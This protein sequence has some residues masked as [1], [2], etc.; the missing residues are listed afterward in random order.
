MEILWDTHTPAGWADRLAQ[1]G[2]AAMQQDWRY[3]AVAGAMGAKAGRAVLRDGGRDLALAQVLARRGLRVVSRGP[4]WLDCADPDRRRAALRRLARCTSAMVATPDAPLCGFGL[5]PVVTPRHHALWDLTPDP[6]CLRAALAPKWRSTLT[7]AEGDGLILTRSPAAL[8]PLLAAE[9]AQR[10]TRGY[11]ALPSAFARAWA[12]APGQAQ[13]LSWRPGGR[14]EA[15]ILVLRHGLR[16][17]YHI[18]WASDRGRA[19]HAHWPLL[20]HMALNLRAAGVTH[21][22][23]GDVD[24]ERNPGLARFKLGTG[25]ALVSLGATCLVLPG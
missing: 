25:A 6:A 12:D 8:E 1:A 21:L 15:A 2:G 14:T 24:T 17:S 18:G 9:D 20:W 7:R 16:A 13:V 11:R 4:V 10:R 3:G 5:V 23:L 22:D 19:V